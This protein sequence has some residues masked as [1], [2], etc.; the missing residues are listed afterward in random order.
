[1]GDDEA[2]YAFGKQ[3]AIAKWNLEKLAN[4]LT[5]EGGENVHP[6]SGPASANANGWLPVATA[7]EV[8]SQFDNV[9]QECF[10][11]RILI[12]LGLPSCYIA[13]DSVALVNSAASGRLVSGW[14]HWLKA[15]EADYHVAS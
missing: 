10:H 5:G 1:M 4:A 9:F 11:Y 8:L 2:R 7:Q 6:Q 14:L 15:S 3:P 12:R 13:G